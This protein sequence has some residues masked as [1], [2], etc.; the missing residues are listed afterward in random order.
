MGP[1]PA[2]FGKGARLVSLSARLSLLALAPVLLAPAPSLTG[3][4]VSA[5]QRDWSKAVVAT[6]DGGFMMGNPEAPVKLVEYGSLTCPHCAHFGEVGVPALVERYVKP[7]KVSFEFRN[8]VLNA[9]DLSGAMLSRCAGA[10]RFF[11]LSDRILATQAEWTGR[12]QALSPAEKNAV[13]ALPR[14]EQLVRIAAVTGFDRLAT[15]HGVPPAKIATC[16]SNDTTVARLV[17]MKR[18]AQ[19][20]HDVHGTPSF[21]IN[22]K[23]AANVHDWATLEP[24]LKQPGG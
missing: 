18:I 4:A 20:R 3:A 7:G 1:A 11:V 17:E 16:L 2:D 12:V 22:G 5:V 13:L 23:L 24:L 15:A 9:F 14:S 21:L 8:F 6:P 10:D 19:E